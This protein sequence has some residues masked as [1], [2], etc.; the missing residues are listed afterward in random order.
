MFK[1]YSTSPIDVIDSSGKWV[2]TYRYEPYLKKWFYIEP[3]MKGTLTLVETEDVPDEVKSSCD[4]IEYPHKM[5]SY[6]APLKLQ[7]QLNSSCNYNCRMCYVSPEMK[8]A[9]LTIDELDELFGKIK[10]IGIV[11]VNF[12]GGEIF[13]RKDIK[14]IVKTAQRHNLLVSC[15]TN[16]I[17]PGTRLD[18]YEQLLSDLYMLQISC[19]GIEE[20]YN[21]EYNTTRWHKAKRCIENVVKST[22]TNILSFVVTQNNYNDIPE[23]IEFANKIKPT[24]IKFGTICWSGKSKNKQIEEYYSTIIPQ[25]REHIARARIKYPNLQIQSQL[26]DS[27]STPLWEEFINGYR[28]YEFYFSPEGKDGLYLSALGIYYPFPLLS[29]NKNF[30]LGRMK[31]D[32]MDIWQN[33]SILKDLRQVTFKNSACGKTNCKGACGLWNRSYA[34]AWSGDIYGKVPCK[35]TEWK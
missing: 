32:I 13:M 30:Q 24:I 35:L 2:S 29:D 34:I 14:D 11:R 17:I 27:E 8:N 12:V 4:I 31:D 15:I 18:I 25:A 26:D 33:N 21:Y 6:Y 5:N 22:S 7:I 20:S 3:T 19:N 1:D 28:P 16:G 10:D 9:V 23:F